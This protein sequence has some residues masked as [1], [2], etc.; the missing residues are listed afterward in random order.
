MRHK[1]ITAAV[2]I[3]ILAGGYFYFNSGS[4][5]VGT[6]VYAY[7]TASKGMIAQSVSG[8]GQVSVADQADVKS[9]VAGD[10]TK[11]GVSAGQAVKT[12][13]ILVQLDS[14]DAQK[15][16][17]DA[18]AGLDS[19][20]LSLE[21]MKQDNSLLILQSQD[22]VTAAEQSLQDGKDNLNKDYAQGFTSVASAFL[23]LPSIMAGLDD[24]VNGASSYVTQSSSSYLDYYYNG[25]KNYDSTAAKYQ[26]E[27]ALAY[28]T[29]KSKYD[30]NFLNYKS[31]SRFSDPAVIESLVNETYETTKSASEAIK[32]VNNLVQRYEDVLLGQNIKPQTF[33]D[34][35]LTILGGYT[36]KINS[37]LAD[38]I[39]F[40]QTIQNDKDA[41]E[42][43][44]RTI[45]EKIKSLQNL[46]TLT[47][48]YNIQS[49]EL[50]VQQKE[51][52]LSDAKE[53]LAYYTIRA[54]FDGAVASVDVKKADSIAVNS[55]VA[56]II[57]NQL[58][59]NI[60]L[61]EVDVASVKTDQKATLTFDAVSDL[62]LT[63]HVA[64][65]DTIGTVSQGVVSYNV[66]IAFDTQ[67]DRIKPGMSATAAI[68]TKVKS[69]VLLV[70][71]SAV[72]S[73]A[74]G[75]YVEI[76]VQPVNGESTGSS[77]TGQSTRQQAVVAGLSDDNSTEI[78]SGLGEGDAIV[79]K[80]TAQAAA[81]TTQSSGSLFNMFGGGG[82]QRT[83]GGSTT[84]TRTN[85]SNVR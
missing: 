12:G 30:A 33:A 60:S 37:H 51:S 27:A 84:T 81:K 78:V 83:T 42:S 2:I 54:P 48:P 20:N 85:S 74:A 35:Q 52:A 69:D 9:K 3:L 7:G 6:V 4:K 43:A 17:R 14:T 59:A 8:S 1:K 82:P 19:A 55:A 40:K 26:N 62:T 5:S 65:I 36:T 31:A 16:V 49:Q 57:T 73:N 24:I 22:A 76:P 68:I 72:K 46:K 11:I 44:Q 28:Q 13:D 41:I 15:A 79:I 25:I 18:Q 50:N 71:N 21:K 39:S 58:T 75:N 34:T 61:N 70:P 66:M 80:T 53:T 56:T 23:D 38:L 67:D 77:A 29:A 45:D 10:V 63:G 32:N 47:N 64:E